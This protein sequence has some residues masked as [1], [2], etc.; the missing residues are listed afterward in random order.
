MKKAYRY[1]VTFEHPVKP[2]ETIKGTVLTTTPYRA[3]DKAVRTAMEQ[4][5]GRTWDSIVVL[6]ERGTDHD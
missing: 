4:R 6:L 5:R 2:T 1:Q 3:A